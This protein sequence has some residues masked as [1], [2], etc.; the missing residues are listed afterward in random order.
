M[1]GIAEPLERHDN[2]GVELLTLGCPSTTAYTAACD[3]TYMGQQ[4]QQQK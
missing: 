2:N 1:K 3:Y 4:Q